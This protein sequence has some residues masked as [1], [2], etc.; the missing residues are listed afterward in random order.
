[1][2]AAN[3]PKAKLRRSEAV[4]KPKAVQKNKPVNL[5][6]KIKLL[7]LL[8]IVMGL[9]SCSEQRDK[10]AAIKFGEIV[11]FYPAF[12]T[13]YK[14]KI[15]ER[16]IQLDFNE[17]AINENSYVDLEL[18]DKDGNSIP[19][20]QYY[21]NGEPFSGGKYHRFRANKYTSNKR[22]K[23]GVKFL[24]GVSEDHFKGYL[25]VKKSDL[26]RIDNTDL[27]SSG[28]TPILYRWTA[29]YKRRMHP[30][31]V[32]IL[33]GLATILTGL[34][35]WFILLKP[36]FYPRFRGGEIE[37]ITPDLGSIRLKG[38]RKIHIGGKTKVK[39]G[40]LS[41]L[42]TG[43]IRQEL[44]GRDFDITLEPHKKR[45]TVWTRYKAESNLDMTPSNRGTFYNFE[46]YEF[47]EVDG[48]KFHFIYKNRKHKRRY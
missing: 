39:Q 42:F 26:D 41:K 38:A 21:M 16:E 19:N 7:S 1:V 11:E 25:R 45:G 4:Q 2:S 30:I 27:A 33:I 43:K 6:N 48:E 17:Y 34:L 44:R 46:E 24:E 13:D 8:L 22:I 15:L 12:G 14:A 47:Q 20:V 29:Q 9:V 10:K 28:Q 3:G 36:I 23:L 5:F 40:G 37:F 32:G 35:L 18:V 31:V